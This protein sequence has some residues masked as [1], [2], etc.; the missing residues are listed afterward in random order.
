MIADALK[1]TAYFGER[2]RAGR[3]FVATALLDALARHGVHASALLRGAEGFGYE[4]HLRAQRLLTLSEDLPAV[5]M[6]LDRR[7]VVEAAL[8]DVLERFGDGLLTLERARLMTAAGAQT[9]ALREQARLTLLCGRHERVGSGPAH[10][11][12]VDVL[13]A[14]GVDGASVLLGVDG[15]VHGERRRARLLGAN[16]DVPSVVLAVGDGERIASA[17]PE[18]RALLDEP[19]VALERVRVC[20]RDGALLVR[21]REPPAG[22]GWWQKLTVFTGTDAMHAG[23]PL[24]PALLRRLRREGAA[25]ATSLRGIWGFHGDHPPHGDRLLALRRRVPAILVVIDAP[26]RAERWFDVIDEMTTESGLVTSE[27]VPALRATSGGARAGTLEL[28]PPSS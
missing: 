18:L 28:A 8:P 14:H 25:G 21:P 4:H 6:A 12:A 3:T 13:R 11:A 26:E 1:L 22:V 2:D 19:V 5:V 24:A 27:V 7:E 23:R 17:L 16:R 10:A 9:P 20:K 15:M